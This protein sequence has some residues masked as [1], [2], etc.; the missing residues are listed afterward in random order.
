MKTGNFFYN[1]RAAM[2]QKLEK[3]AIDL[4]PSGKGAG[5]TNDK[6]RQEQWRAVIVRLD[7]AFKKLAVDIRNDKNLRG[8]QGADLMQ[9]LNMSMKR[10]KEMGGGLASRDF[11]EMA[12][13]AVEEQLTLGEADGCGHNPNEVADLSDTAFNL[14][15]ECAELKSGKSIEPEMM[16]N[17]EDAFEREVAKRCCSGSGIVEEVNLCNM[18]ELLKSMKV[19]LAEEKRSKENP[20][21]TRAEVIE[22]PSDGLGK[23]A[24]I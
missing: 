10:V 21:E 1:N 18:I 22:K 20:V 8:Q 2:I 14:W 7:A 23:T 24:D 5:E 13:P 6:K 11:D 3:Q 12:K 9:E 15:L 17:V 16:K 4:F 19:Q